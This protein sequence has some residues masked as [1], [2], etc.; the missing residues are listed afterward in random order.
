MFPP[1]VS[2]SSSLDSIARTE[3]PLRHERLVD[4]NAWTVIAKRFCVQRKKIPIVMSSDD[5]DEG[6][7]AD[8][9]QERTSCDTSD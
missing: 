1:L 7:L 9:F 6:G 3:S 4:R 8:V 5:D 2:C